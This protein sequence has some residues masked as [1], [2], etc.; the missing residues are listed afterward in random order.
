MT[1]DGFRVQDRH[2]TWHR[3]AA[4]RLVSEAD[5]L[6]VASQEAPGSSMRRTAS[7][8]SNSRSSTMRGGSPSVKVRK[9]KGESTWHLEEGKSKKPPL[10]SAPEGEV[11]WRSRMVKLQARELGFELD[12]ADVKELG[13][14]SMYHNAMSR[15]M[16]TQHHSPLSPHQ[17]VPSRQ[18]RALHCDLENTSQSLSSIGSQ[19][20]MSEMGLS[21]RSLPRSACLVGPSHEENPSAERLQ[22]LAATVMHA[23]PHMLQHMC[24]TAGISVHTGGKLPKAL[25]SS[26]PQ[27]TVEADVA[28]GRPLAS[29]RTSTGKPLPVPYWGRNGNAPVLREHPELQAARD[30]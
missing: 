4:T 29:P 11:K 18:L 16:H 1:G 23:G 27:H 20:V 30:L 19:A 28:I 8:P 15:N 10:E 12:Q 13:H 3:F 2:P 7:L 26:S 6:A 5:E 9:K 14:L 17:V 25:Q 24:Q 22:E 21:T